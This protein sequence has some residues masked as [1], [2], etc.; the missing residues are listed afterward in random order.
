VC[1]VLE[2][3]YAV[4]SHNLYGGDE[5]A[6]KVAGHELKS[7][8]AYASAGMI[9]GLNFALMCL[10]DYRGYRLIASSVLPISKV[11]PLLLFREL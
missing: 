7:L 2:W 9:L 3:Q 4:D 1:G 11:R 5:F 6:A 10:I 8:N